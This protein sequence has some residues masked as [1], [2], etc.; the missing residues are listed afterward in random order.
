MPEPETPGGHNVKYALSLS[1]AETINSA[2]YSQ[3]YAHVLVQTCVF[4][5]ERN[6]PIW[7]QNSTL[8][9]ALGLVLSCQM[10]SQAVMDD[11]RSLTYSWNLGIADGSPSHPFPLDAM[12][13]A[14]K[15]ARIMRRNYERGVDRLGSPETFGQWLGLHLPEHLVEGVFA[16]EGGSWRQ[17]ANLALAADNMV[18]GIAATWRAS[19]NRMAS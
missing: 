2:A 16:Q 7:P 15:H 3:Q 8:H 10:D 4:D 12:E 19:L 9:P 17:V 18:D 13:R 14:I 1:I 11:R 5:T 6:R